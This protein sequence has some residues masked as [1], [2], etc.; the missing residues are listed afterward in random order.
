MD[1]I[2]VFRDTAKSPLDLYLHTS[3]ERKAIRN[4]HVRRNPT[5]SVTNSEELREF[6]LLEIVKIVFQLMG[7]SILNIDDLWP[8]L[9]DQQRRKTL[10]LDQIQL[11]FDNY[12]RCD[13]A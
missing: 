7:A 13:H 9:G 3:F 6:I 5:S 4:G 8:C 2:Y 12:I 1:Q 11:T 10:L